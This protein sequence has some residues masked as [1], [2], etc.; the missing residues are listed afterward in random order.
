CGHLFGQSCAK[1]W[2][3]KYSLKHRRRGTKII[4]KCPE[5]N[6]ESAW[7]DVRPIYARSITAVDGAVLDELRKDVAQ[8]N[9]TRL[10]LEDQRAELRMDYMKMHVQ[11]ERLRKELDESVRARDWLEL[12]NV[13][14]RR[15]V[16]EHEPSER[17][18]ASGNDPGTSDKGPGASDNVLDGPGDPGPRSAYVPRMRLRAAIPMTVQA[19]ESSRLLVVHP[20]EPLVYASYSKPLLRMHTLAQ[21]D[22]HG[23]SG[24]A[25]LLDLP[26]KQEIRGAEVSPHATG[27]RYMLTASLD[28]TAAVTS[29][30]YG[31]SAAAAASAVTACVKRPSPMLAVTLGV[32]APCWSCAWDQRDANLC[33]VGT[34]SG[35]VVAFDL[36]RADAPVRT[37]NGPQD[38]VNMLERPEGDTAI[39]GGS[40]EPHRLA[41]GY[42]PIHSIITM[43]DGRLLVANS[44]GLFLLPSDPSAPAW[45][46]LTSPSSRSC[47]SASYDAQQ[48]CLAASFRT[49]RA[50]TRA[51]STEHELFDVGSGMDAD[52]WWR[53]RRASIT[54]P[55]PQTKMARTSVFSYAVDAG[56]RRQGLFCA[57]VEA[58]RLV[59]AW[60]VDG[61][62][63]RDVLALSGVAA[64]EDIVDVR[65]WQWD[66]GDAMFASLTNTTVR[67][68]DVR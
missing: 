28:Q 10:R 18:G 37:W 38:G 6:Q 5:C 24:K 66:D 55:S 15:R 64:S 68:Y 65:G 45:T 8:L 53:R 52:W 12:E 3:R 58:T 2:L 26:H 25:F 29:L 51:P 33:Y 11:V 20:H 63:N 39:S 14:L 35:R 32:R 62:D 60:D 40:V 47:F 13:A 48:Q 27:A 42:S 21:I 56:A 44:N 50:D 43:S 4:G 59:K 30:G 7:S 1:K 41:T 54:V 46:Q 31:P 19:Q 17:G 61:C 67:L 23:A 16:E 9:E 49:Q 57:G 34:T 36:R 22:M